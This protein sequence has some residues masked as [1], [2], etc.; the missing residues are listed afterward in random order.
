MCFENG[1]LAA[2]TTPDLRQVFT[3]NL[4]GSDSVVAQV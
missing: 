1:V 3:T 4:M 2:G